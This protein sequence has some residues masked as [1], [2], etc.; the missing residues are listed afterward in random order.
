M[1]IKIII[2]VEIRNK[3]KIFAILVQPLKFLV[4]FGPNFAIFDKVGK[5]N[6]SKN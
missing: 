3:F 5:I 2:I 4:F 6:F 1:V